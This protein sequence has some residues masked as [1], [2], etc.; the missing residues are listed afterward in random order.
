MKLSLS[1]SCTRLKRDGNR[2]KFFAKNASSLFGQKSTT[3]NSDARNVKGLSANGL[4]T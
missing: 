4:G 1:W 2:K 3:I